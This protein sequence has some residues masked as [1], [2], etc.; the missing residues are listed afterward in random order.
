MASKDTRSGAMELEGY[1]TDKI[2]NHYMPWYDRVF[3]E[4]TGRPVKVLEL[5]VKEGESLKLWRDY[6]PRGNIS[7]ID[8]KLPNGVD[9]G[10]RV[11]LFCG[12]QGD[13][14]FLSRV[15][16]KVAPDG[17][18]VIID[19]ASHLGALT[20]ISFWHLFQ[21]HLR[22]GGVYA[23]EDWGTG[24]WEEWPDGRRLDLAQY[25]HW[26]WAAQPLWMKLLHRLGWPT[27][28]VSPKTPMP[29]HSHGMVGFV[30]QLID[31]QGASDVTKRRLGGVPER[32]S[33]FDSVLVTPNI[34]FVIKRADVA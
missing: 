2:R 5:G 24:Y 12:S 16:D 22:A 33:M 25:E 17:F 23:I 15:A 10:D 13:R 3:S 32:E 1:G 18:D 34:V 9:L 21:N 29:C 31:E 20:R 28:P 6:F 27:K 14:A 30:K 7:G 11:E 4:F 19:D 8:V 26:Q